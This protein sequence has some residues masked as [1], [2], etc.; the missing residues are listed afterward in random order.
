MVEVCH[1][2]VGKSSTN[3]EHAVL[4]LSQS[5]GRFDSTVYQAHFNGINFTTIAVIGAYR[6]PSA[7]TVYSAQCATFPEAAQR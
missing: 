6:Q 2:P 1:T 3:N 5:Q 4:G 7:S